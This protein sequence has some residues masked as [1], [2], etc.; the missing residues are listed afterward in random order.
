MAQAWVM[1][2]CDDKVYTLRACI[3]SAAFIACR[4]LTCCHH[5]SRFVCK[6]SLMS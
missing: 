6:A 4:P 1:S 5:S 3:L 2:L